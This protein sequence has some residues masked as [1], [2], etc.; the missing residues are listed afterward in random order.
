MI[1]IPCKQLTRSH[2]QVKT[3]ISNRRRMRCYVASPKPIH[4]HMDDL[5]LFKLCVAQY[6]STQK[7]IVVRQF[8]F[9]EKLNFHIPWNHIKAASYVDHKESLRHRCSVRCETFHSPL[10]VDAIDHATPTVMDMLA[11]FHSLSPHF[12]TVPCGIS[13]FNF[14]RPVFIIHHPS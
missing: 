10:V 1:F 6:R 8:T 3:Y 14:L 11:L 12:I 7:V 4:K 13:H 9:Y 5:S 2:D